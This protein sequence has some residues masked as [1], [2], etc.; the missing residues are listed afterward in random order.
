MTVTLACVWFMVLVASDPGGGK[1]HYDAKSA[2]QPAVTVTAT[3]TATV[4]VTLTPS[5]APAMATPTAGSTPTPSVSSPPAEASKIAVP[6]QAPPAFEGADAGSGSKDRDD[7]RNGGGE[8]SRGTVSYR[9]CSDVK[10][11]DANPIRR[12]DPG[13][14]R[15]LDRDGDGVACE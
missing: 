4:M 3:A 10:A 11:A 7:A 8:G 14:G 15:H 13:Y 9:N 5:P 1:P 12:G 6:R 2:P